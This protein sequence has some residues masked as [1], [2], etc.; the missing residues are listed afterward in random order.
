MPSLW[1][2]CTD[3][4]MSSLGFKCIDLN[5]L[6]L[7]SKCSELIILSL[8]WKCFELIMLSL[9]LKCIDLIQVYDD[10]D[11]YSDDQEREEEEVVGRPRFGFDIFSVFVPVTN[12][13]SVIW[14]LFC[15]FVLKMEKYVSLIPG[16]GI[17]CRLNEQRISSKAKWP[18]MHY[19]YNY[20]S[21]CTQ[22]P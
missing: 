15:T 22:F 21:Q 13:F 19:T 11:D 12:F 5:M 18:K 4:I 17:Y 14:K 20:N 6:S 8:W 16:F 2:K 7:W 10:N 3:L 9:W 1:L